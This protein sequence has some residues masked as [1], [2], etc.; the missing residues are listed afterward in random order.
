MSGPRDT[1]RVTETEV[2]V[3]TAAENMSKWK[4]EIS[5]VLQENGYTDVRRVE[6]LNIGAYTASRT[7]SVETEEEETNG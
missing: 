4:G 5:E 3:K 1:I 6:T 7:K 2:I